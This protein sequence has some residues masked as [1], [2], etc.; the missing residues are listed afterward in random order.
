[1]IFQ[2]FHI[3]FTLPIYELVYNENTVKMYQLVMIFH[4]YFVFFIVPSH[5]TS[6]I[7]KIFWNL[8]MDNHEIAVKMYLNCMKVALIIDSLVILPGYQIALKFTKRLLWICFVK[9]II[10]TVWYV[11]IYICIAQIQHI[12]CNRICEN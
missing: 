7:M 10:M 6:E 5:A 2:L 9:Y 11:A 12:I 8:I 3:L 4:S 1:M